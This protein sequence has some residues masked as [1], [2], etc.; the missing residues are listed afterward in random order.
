MGTAIIPIIH[1]ICKS[2]WFI[3]EAKN[4]KN[5]THENIRN[6]ITFTYDFVGEWLQVFAQ[7]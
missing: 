3:L 5:F 7:F 1:K 2:K 4:I 6:K